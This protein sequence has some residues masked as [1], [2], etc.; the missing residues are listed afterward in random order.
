M[1]IGFLSMNFLQISD[2]YKSV[3]KRGP[4]HLGCGRRNHSRLLKKSPLPKHQTPLRSP[5]GV[6]TV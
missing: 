1:F 6:F 5:G 2:V 4:G 3:L